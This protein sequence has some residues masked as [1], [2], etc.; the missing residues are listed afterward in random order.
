MHLVT[1]SVRLGKINKE[2]YFSL[3]VKQEVRLKC[4]KFA[5]D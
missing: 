1:S 4:R 5:D 2:D 3:H